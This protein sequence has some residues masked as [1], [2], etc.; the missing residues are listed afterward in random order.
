MRLLRIVTPVIFI[1]VLAIWGLS[2]YQ[3]INEA[4]HTNPVIH[5]TVDEL[6]LS[7]NDREDRLLEGLTATDEQDGDLTQ[8]IIVV[9]RVKGK[10]SGEYKVTYMVFDQNNNMG[11]Y[12][13]TIKYEDYKP[14][15][16]NLKNPM[17]LTTEDTFNVNNYLEVIDSIDGD[18]TAS[19]QV[20]EN[21]YKPGVEGKYEI[22]VSV[23]NSNGD[24]TSSTFPILVIDQG[25]SSLEIKLT[26]SMTIL[27]KGNFFDSKEFL[28]S[29]T[30]SNGT[31]GNSTYLKISNDV[32]MDT[33]GYYF[34]TYTYKSNSYEGKN[35]LEV[36]VTE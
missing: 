20:D 9:N 1:I 16:I 35:A 12:V 18:L 3:T 30:T 28:E 15:V 10:K 11:E 25:K 22:T 5:S 17:I 19:I 2:V 6:S 34:V 21:T 14:P 26:E 8:D 7:V 36:V 4:D 33:P 13:R 24:T 29:M 31:K 32:D 23:S 27:K